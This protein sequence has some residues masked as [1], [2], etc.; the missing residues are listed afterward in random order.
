[1][2]KARGGLDL[3]HEPVGADLRRQLRAQ[4]LE[5]DPAVVAE[6]LGQDHHRHATCTQLAVD[7]VPRGR[8]FLG[9]SE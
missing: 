4:H 5:R 6:I 3:A 1:M 2:G 8:R 9:V 7:A